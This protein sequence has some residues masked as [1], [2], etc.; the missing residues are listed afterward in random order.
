MKRIP[1]TLVTGTTTALREQAIASALPQLNGIAVILEGLP[2]GTS[3]LANADLTQAMT[4]V[5][6]APGCVCCTG[7]LTMQVTLNR[8]LRTHPVHLFISL[9]DSRHLP[10]IRQ[11]LT[12]EPY[13][14]WLSLTKEIHAGCRSN[15]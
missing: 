10:Q 1:T 7:N 14:K 6:I 3:P 9:A 2:D 12:Q 4:I 8:L 15:T 11:F 13:D 5:R